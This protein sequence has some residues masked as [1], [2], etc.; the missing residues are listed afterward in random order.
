MQS[1]ILSYGLK[2]IGRS[3]FRGCTS[4]ENISLPDSVVEIGERA[5][6]NCRIKSITI[7]DSVTY[8]ADHA[9]DFSTTIKCTENSTADTYA[10]ENGYIVEYLNE[11]G[12]DTQII[13]WEL[14]D[15]TLII[16]GEGM[17]PNDYHP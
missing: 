9:F 10:H 12:A 5:F 8:I 1:I 4:L 6:E 17:I 7:P 2:S 13:K 3:A 11:E 16:S 15:S 14:R